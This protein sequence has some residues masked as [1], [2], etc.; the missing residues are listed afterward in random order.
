ML[1]KQVD[2]IRQLVGP[3]RYRTPS[4]DGGSIVGFLL[5]NEKLP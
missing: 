1:S 4:Y 2:G 5:M 3:T